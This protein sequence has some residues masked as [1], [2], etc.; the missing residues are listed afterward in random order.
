MVQVISF[1]FLPYL[2]VFFFSAF[3]MQINLNATFITKFIMLDKLTLASNK[4]SRH[5]HCFAEML[6]YAYA[7]L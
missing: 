6:S 2:S 7:P 5:M 3:Y 1:F 4:I